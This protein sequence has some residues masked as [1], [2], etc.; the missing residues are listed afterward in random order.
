M[1][2]RPHPP[3]E[4]SRRCR[5]LAF[6]ASLALAFCAV[7]HAQV[8]AGPYV[9]SPSVIVDR[10]LALAR[11]GPRD[12]LVDLGSGDGRI[13]ITAARR[14][15]ARGY[16]VDIDPKLVALVRD[17]AERAGVGD[18]V[19]FEERDLFA[20]DLSR[21]TVVTIYLLP[22]SATQ[23]VD[24]LRGE[25]R[26]GTRVV[27]H[28]YPLG[29]WREDGVEV[30]DVPEKVGISGSSRTVLYLYTVPARV[31][32]TWDLFL[33]GRSQPLRLAVTDAPFRTSA[34]VVE[35]GQ[36]RPLPA[37]SVRADEVVAE[38][39]RSPG[40]PPLRLTG[41]AEGDVMTGTIAD[42]PGVGWRA[43]RVEAGKKTRGSLRLRRIG[44]PAAASALVS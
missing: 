18:L 5:L 20:T 39:P 35:N 41:K 3:I 27:S 42:L 17:N 12:T 7:A 11:V 21:A 1:F 15:G 22:G 2:A 8:I 26:P 33:P 6:G 44:E 37:F 43:V 40:R 9:P 28:D 30:L 34:S 32:G 4:I 29:P 19:Q 31:G 25:L 38:I 10:M 14:Y 24:K 36:T 13:V 16:G 23:L